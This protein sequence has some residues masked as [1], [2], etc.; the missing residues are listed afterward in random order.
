[1]RVTNP[2]IIR[3][4]TKEWKGDR[5]SNGRP[6]V[7]DDI[8]DRMKL[9]T[10]EEA[11]WTCRR[12]GYHFQFAGDWLNLHPDRVIVGR[13]VTCRWVPTRPDVHG[14]LIKQGEDENRIGGQ[15]SWVIDELEANDLIVVDLF[16]K[17]LNLSL[18]HI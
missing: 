18:I 1:M 8:L 13:A 3:S 6:L 16:G 10:T 2:E 11:W 5:D 7:P 12:N 15:N 9:V 4:V 14:S 17:V